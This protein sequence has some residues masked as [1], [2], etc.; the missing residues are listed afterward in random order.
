M[1]FII[2]FLL[3]GLFIFYKL[4]TNPDGEKYVEIRIK[5]ELIVAI[6]LTERTNTKILLLTKDNKYQE[7]KILKPDESLPENVSGY[8]LLYI[9]NNG[10]EVLDA[11]CP[12]RIIVKQGFTKYANIPLICLPRSLVITINSNNLMSDIDVIA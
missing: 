10:V 11:D 6:K 5:N 9:Y 4:S 2:L 3:L 12:L 1:S 7:Y 8:D